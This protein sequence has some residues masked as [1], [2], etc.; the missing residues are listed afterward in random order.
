[1]RQAVCVLIENLSL[2]RMPFKGDAVIDGWQWLIN[3]TLRSL[4]LISS[5]SRQ[6]IKDAAVSAL[7]ALCKEYYRKLPGEAG[8][9]I[10]GE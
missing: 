10:E 5:H 4:H 1:M 6:Q 9:A 3:D 2:S 7:S 8:P